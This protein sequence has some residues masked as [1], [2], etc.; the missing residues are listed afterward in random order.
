MERGDLPGGGFSGAIVFLW[1][2]PEA[3]ICSFQFPGIIGSP[4][5]SEPTQIN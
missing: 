3:W 4:F 5:L 1:P 2:R